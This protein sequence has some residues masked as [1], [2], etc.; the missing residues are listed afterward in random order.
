MRTL[1]GYLSDLRL[2][3]YNNGKLTVSSKS[4]EMNVKLLAAAYYKVNQWLQKASL[5]LDKDKQEL[6][7]YTRRQ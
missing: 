2:S 4:L 1:P 7:H 6:M 5:T 3:P